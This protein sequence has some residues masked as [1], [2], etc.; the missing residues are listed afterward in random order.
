M[1]EGRRRWL[2]LFA[3]LLVGTARSTEALSYSSSTPWPIPF[4]DGLDS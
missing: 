2:L 4:R 3:T 1:T